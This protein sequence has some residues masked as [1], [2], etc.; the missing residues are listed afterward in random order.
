MDARMRCRFVVRVSALL[1]AGSAHLA[2][3]ERSQDESRER[4]GDERSELVRELLTSDTESDD[5][6][7]LYS[8]ADEYSPSD[9]TGAPLVSRGVPERGEGAPRHWDP[10][11]RKFGTSDYVL[12]G[13]SVGLSAAS[14][15]VPVPAKPWTRTNELDEWGRRTISAPTYEQGR[16]AQDT[17]D[18]VLS[19]GVA[20]PLLVDS[21]IVGYWYRSSP[22]VAGQMALIAIETMAVSSALQGIASAAFARERPYGRDCGTQ[23]PAEHSDCTSTV[24]Y[25]SYYSGHSSL[26][27]A[28]AAVTC[29]FHAQHDLFGDPLADGL[30]CGIALGSAATV[31]LMRVV[32]MKHYVTDVATGAAI[33]T[34]TGFALPWLLHYGPAAA[35]DTGAGAVRFSVYPLGTGL[36]VGGTF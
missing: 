34:L 33:G 14:S 31:G 19:L 27:F 7:W 28:A 2:A 1:L 10:R 32:G 8:H 6:R 13:V 29:T 12:T 21:L 26:S 36:A 15:F 5:L 18:V 25:R 16:W 3:E 35:V 22:E 17:S 30:T 20:F 23:I 11:W 24:R 4:S 9:L